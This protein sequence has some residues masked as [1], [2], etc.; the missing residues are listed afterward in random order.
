MLAASRLAIALLILVAFVPEPTMP[1]RDRAL[2]RLKSLVAEQSG[3][4]TD[5]QLLEIES[6]AKSSRAA[7]LAKFLQ[8]Y[9]K[10]SKGDFEQAASLFDEVSA[11]SVNLGDYALYFKALSLNKQSRCKEVAELAR[12]LAESYPDSLYGKA[13]LLLSGNCFLQAKNYAAAVSVVSKLAEDNDA[14]ALMLLARSYEAEGRLE[15]ALQTYER[16]YYEAPASP[17]SSEAQTLLLAKGKAVP[18][19][20]RR[21]LTRAE[22]LYKAGMYAAC[23]EAFSLIAT[24]MPLLLDSSQSRLMFGVSL[25]NIGKHSLAIKYLLSVDASSE[26]YLKA[27]FLAAISAQKVGNL[28]KFTE[29]ALQLLDTNLPEEYAAEL[30]AKLIE[31]NSRY[32]P[33]P[34]REIQS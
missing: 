8:A 10:Y 15:E 20:G 1:D 28:E 33:R 24:E 11:K 23:A 22:R 29:L 6:S 13:A 30:L 4:P 34:H 32:C 18:Q 21:L 17:E 26:D 14:A 16:I 12:R 2:A 9:I 31:I 5:E 27:R 3:Q 19:V 7:A 25:H